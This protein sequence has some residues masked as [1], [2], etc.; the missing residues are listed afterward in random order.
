[1][2]PLGKP[3]TFVEIQW[4]QK[5]NDVKMIMVDVPHIAKTLGLEKS[6]TSTTS[7]KCLD[8]EKTLLGNNFFSMKIM[9]C[10]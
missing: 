7:L 1:M 2:V 3:L 5:R 8:V 4:F 10:G 9:G 6:E